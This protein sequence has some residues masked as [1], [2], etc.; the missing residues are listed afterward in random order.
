MRDPAMRLIVFTGVA[1]VVVGLAGQAGW[2][3]AVTAKAVVDGVNSIVY[4]EGEVEG[5][6]VPPLAVAIPMIASAEIAAFFFLGFFWISVIRAR[7]K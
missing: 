2:D 4:G 1:L 6:L 5:E 3:P 7:G